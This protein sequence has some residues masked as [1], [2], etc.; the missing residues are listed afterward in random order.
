MTYSVD[1]VPVI[2]RAVGKLE[3]QVIDLYDELI[4][5]NESQVEGI[6]IVQARF[7]SHHKLLVDLVEDVM[8]LKDKN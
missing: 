6:R 2:D 8:K 5:L 1:R 3:G 4:K 7:E